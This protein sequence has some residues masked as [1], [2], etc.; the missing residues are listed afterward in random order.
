MNKSLLLITFMTV[1][2]ADNDQHAEFISSQYVMNAN[3]DKVQQNA[4]RVARWLLKKGILCVTY[5]MTTLI[6]FDNDRM[7]YVRIS[8]Q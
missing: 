6:L 4:N 2:C 8:K 7:K 5:G 3:N 1:F